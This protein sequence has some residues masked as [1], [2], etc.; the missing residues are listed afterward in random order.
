MPDNGSGSFT[1]SNG[2][3]TGSGL[4]AADQAAGIKILASHHDEHDQEIADAL[5]NRICKDGQSTPTANIPMGGYQITNLGSA[6]ARTSALSCAQFQDAAA[7][8]G[9]TAGGTANAL[10]LTLSPA[11]TAYATGMVIRFKAGA[12]SNSSANPTVNVNSV[13][14]K[15]IVRG[16]GSTGLSIGEL[17]ANGIYDMIYDGTSFRIRCFAG[18]W[19]TW[20][21]TVA[22]GGTIVLGT[23]TANY[24]K[25]KVDTGEGICHYQLRLTT[26]VDSGTGNAITFTTPLTVAS[27]HIA[28]PDNCTIAQAA[29]VPGVT[30]N[31]STTTYGVGRYDSAN[32]TAGGAALVMIAKG[33]FPI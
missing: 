24:A 14:A 23:V 33:S 2:V 16:D 12:S 32:F 28:A 26:T 22:A 19:E 18:Q 4:W 25:F 31:S 8:Y 7:I 6:T 1:R 11:I 9:G 20:A 21:P 5:S 30:L 29:N 10:T 3:N 17:R 15:N 27:T 13:G